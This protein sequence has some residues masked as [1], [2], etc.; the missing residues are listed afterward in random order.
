MRFCALLVCLAAATLVENAAA[1]ETMPIEVYAQVSHETPYVL[2]LSK[3]RGKLLYVGIDHSTDPESQTIKTIQ[4]LWGSENPDIVLIEG[5]FPPTPSN[6]L[7][8]ATR[9][10]GEA[11]ATAF[12]AKLRTTETASLELPFDDEVTVLLKEFTPEQVALFYSLR[13]L[14][15]ERQRNGSD[16]LTDHLTRRLIPWLARSAPLGQVIT[17]EESLK[18]LVSKQLP[19]LSDWREAPLIWFDPMPQSGALF[20]HAIARRL[21]QLRDGHMAKR[22]AD[23]V[24]QGQNVFAV[25]GASHVVMQ[26]D[27]IRSAL[28]CP[29]REDTND[30]VRLPPLFLKC[31]APG[32]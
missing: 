29:V 4:Q 10:S 24:A 11:G 1:E 2:S 5:I 16:A 13:V 9:S 25:V 6:S 17:S 28:G 22:V 23:H 30:A 31:D 20:T 14:A 7:F 15:Q 3:G 21:V 19:E 26:E 18:S 8:E 12:L 27:R 32:E